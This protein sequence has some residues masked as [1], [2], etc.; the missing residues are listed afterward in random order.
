MNVLPNKITLVA[1]ALHAI[2][3]SDPKVP[4]VLWGDLLPEQQAP[5]TKASEFLS[6]YVHGCPY[7]SVDRAK[8]AA[9]L[10]EVFKDK[11]DL[12][13]NTAVD[14]FLNIASVMV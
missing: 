5:F 1:A 14:S 12:N 13:A 11:L 3:A 9:K 10:E 8:L 7:A 4:K 6:Q 2:S